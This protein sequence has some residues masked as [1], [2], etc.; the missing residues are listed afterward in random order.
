MSAPCDHTGSCPECGKQF[1]AKPVEYT[2]LLRNV[3]NASIRVSGGTPDPNSTIALE[4]GVKVA[5]EKVIARKRTAIG[6]LVGYGP[7]PGHLYRKG[8]ELAHGYPI[9]EAP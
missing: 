3:A 5:I 6:K 4:G 2:L 7:S 1:V 8:F 9:G